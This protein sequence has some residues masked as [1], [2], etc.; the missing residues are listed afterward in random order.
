MNWWIYCADSAAGANI[1]KV[2]LMLSHTLA[3]RTATR[4]ENRMP[5]FIHFRCGKTVH[6]NGKIPIYKIYSPKFRECLQNIYDFVFWFC[7][8]LLHIIKKSNFSFLF[9]VHNLHFQDEIT[10]PICIPL[11]WW[12]EGRWNSG[13]LSFTWTLTMLIMNEPKEWMNEMCKYKTKMK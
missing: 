13:K 8:V 3:K 4:K 11:V 7:F 5:S 9:I 10:Y 2:T 1:N 6:S 12:K